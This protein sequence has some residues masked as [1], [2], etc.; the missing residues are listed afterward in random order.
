MNIKHYIKIEK[1]YIPLIII[2]GGLGLLTAI[3]NVIVSQETEKTIATSS[4]FISLLSVFC[5]L[6]FTVEV[7]LENRHVNESK[8][9]SDYCARFSED[10]SIQNVVDWLLGLCNT[11]TQGGLSEFSSMMSKGNEY[12]TNN[13]TILDKNRFIQF[14]AELNL[15]LEKGRL[16]LEDVRELFS[17]Y[18]VIF[19]KVESDEKCIFG[20]KE[21]NVG[22]RD[23]IEKISF[24]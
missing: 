4:L 19:N 17:F 23:F 14:Y 20:N 24:T 11:E 18:A 5:T 21:N 12:N 9:L 6:Y 22:F 3:W 7:A 2:I 1:K 15:Q 13:P 8:L 16:N 10:Y